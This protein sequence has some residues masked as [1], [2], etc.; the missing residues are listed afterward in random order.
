MQAIASIG[1]FMKPLA[2]LLQPIMGVMGLVNNMRQSSAI[3]SEVGMME[4]QQKE[5]QALF[6]NP[7]LLAAKIR[8]TETPLSKGLVDDV[9]Q[10][11]NA[12]LASQGATTAPYYQSYVSQRAL[13]PYA[14]QEQQ[15]AVSALMRMM[16]LPFDQATQLASTLA[17]NKSDNAG[18]Y[19][20]LLQQGAPSN[21]GFDPGI[22]D[23]PN[24]NPPSAPAPPPD[25]PNVDYPPY[26]PLGLPAFDPNSV[27]AGV[28]V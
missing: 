9:Q 24:T 11:T 6:N 27:D 23:T 1:T 17:S 12:N 21:T 13:A 3:N 5:N 20:W 19:Q 10:A 28:I 15:I 26:N 8:A 7:A 2:S 4:K 22:V 25:A 18:F 14:M 16:G